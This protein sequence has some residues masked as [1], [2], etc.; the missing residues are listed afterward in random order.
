MKNEK[1]GIIG[2]GAIGQEIYKKISRKVVKGYTI[3]G[4]FWP[5]SSACWNAR[6]IDNPHGPEP[7]IATLVIHPPENIKILFNKKQHFLSKKLFIIK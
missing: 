2:F 7:I 6:N 4:I 5:F 1:I 3:S